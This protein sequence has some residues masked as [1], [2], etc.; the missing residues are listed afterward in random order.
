MTTSIFLTVALVAIVNLVSSLFFK[1]KGIL[2]CGIVGFSGPTKSRFDL[3]K[4]HTLLYINALE[5]GMH[6]VGIFTPKNGIRKEGNS[7]TDVV[8]KESNIIDTLEPDHQLIGH[9]RHATVG[10]RTENNSH[11]WEFENIVG[12]HNGT[13]KDYSY[14]DYS[15]AKVYD[16]KYTDYDVDSQVL[17]MAID[18]DITSIN[19]KLIPALEHYEGAAALLFYSKSRDTIFACHDKERPLFYGYIGK[20]MYISSIMHTLYII[21]CTDITEFEVNHVHE[22]KNGQIINKFAYKPQS[23]IKKPKAVVYNS[24]I[25]KSSRYISDLDKLVD[26]NCSISA[27][28]LSSQFKLNEMHNI[29]L[30]Y[31]IPK[32]DNQICLEDCIGTTGLH[33]SY[34]APLELIRNYN[35]RFRAY[36]KISILDS[37]TNSLI[38][39]DGT[40]DI[41]RVTGTSGSF[42][43]EIT[44]YIN[45][46]EDNEIQIKP[47]LIDITDFLPL[48][49]QFVKLLCNLTYSNTDKI[50]A[51]KDEV[52]E[53]IRYNKIS[54]GFTLKTIDSE[55]EAVVM[56][57]DF[58]KA[59]KK[60]IISYAED[61]WNEDIYKKLT[62]KDL[63]G[64]TVTFD[65]DDESNS[66]EIPVKSGENGIEKPEIKL[67]DPTE[68]LNEDEQEEEEIDI[69]EVDGDKFDELVDNFRDAFE[70]LNDLV[71]S[72]KINYNSLITKI[73]EY[74]EMSKQINFKEIILV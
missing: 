1:S 37:N 59:T 17:L 55:L 3:K 24:T 8:S 52:L 18:K 39:V 45:N 57:G 11:P 47:H 4:L 2:G 41:F 70:E 53:V 7:Y 68:I 26:K 27:Y 12:L 9:V 60:E 22:I 21:G 66:C 31:I 64:K 35:F 44:G 58:V 15:I 20:S 63:S 50:F 43:H 48:K 10:A 29:D 13:L 40:T 61:V 34:D 73:K 54:G 72:D 36:G 65:K 49:G 5:R 23:R 28:Q 19:E 46:D 42:K 62:G 6:S 69:I 74:N 25:N 16:F 14:N 71:S 51:C 30:R 32:A 67:N 56:P 38:D 33:S